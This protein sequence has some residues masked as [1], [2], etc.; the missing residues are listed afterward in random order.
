MLTYCVG[1]SH[2]SPV[3]AKLVLSRLARREVMIART[4]FRHYT[5]CLVGATGFPEGAVVR[6]PTESLV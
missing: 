3:P 4:G 5:R 1:L 6:A 2:C